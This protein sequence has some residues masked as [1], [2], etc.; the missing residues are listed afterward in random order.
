VQSPQSSGAPR[1]LR[2][3]QCGAPLEAPPFAL[4]TRC[5]YCGHSVKLAE[6][7]AP[8]PTQPAPATGLSRRALVLILVALA[9]A[10]GLAVAL[11]ASIG[12]R[13]TPESPA[14]PTSQAAV[15][16]TEPAAPS[17]TRS[18]PAPEKTD[19]VRYPMRSLL[20]VRTAVD[21]DGSSAHMLE[22]FP[23]I[24]SKRRADELQYSVPLSHPWFSRAE[25]G[26]KN[27]RAGKLTSVSFKPPAGDDKFK[28]Q[29]EIGDCLAKGLGKPEVREI[30][31]L[32]GE[33]SYFW[34]KHFPKAWANLYSGYLWLTFQSPEGIAPV[35]LTTV[36]RTLD[37]CTPQTSQ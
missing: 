18:L 23:T 7:S 35:T 5:G 15:P 20:G 34:G 22:L 12:K 29:K 27:E 33:Q 10:L 16:T 31:H 24:S 36:V 6:P 8:Q 3:P 2:C 11:V 30:D 17:P 9:A 32:A 26:W 1:I 37:G 21:I 13:P 4:T 28:N 19:D 14:Q 25:L